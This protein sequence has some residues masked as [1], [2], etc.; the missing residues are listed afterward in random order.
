MFAGARTQ[1]ALEAF[2]RA[3]SMD[4]RQ[5]RWS[6]RAAALHGSAQAQ[7]MLAARDIPAQPTQ[8]RAHRQRS[9]QN[10]ETAAHQGGR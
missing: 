2:S 4:V 10:S 7:G 9:T 5:A 8:V 3:E 1:E 6:V